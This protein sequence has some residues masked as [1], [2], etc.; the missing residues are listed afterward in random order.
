MKKTLLLLTVILGTTTAN[1]QLKVKAGT[2]I[3]SITGSTNFS[4]SPNENYT[5]DFN[6]RTKSKTGFYAG[7]GY[8]LFITD[9]FSVTPELI[10]N[11]MGANG[12]MVRNKKL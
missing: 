2:N 3:S 9:N 7:L 10:Y 8:E 5:F 11:Q 12:K 1:A 4:I 6:E